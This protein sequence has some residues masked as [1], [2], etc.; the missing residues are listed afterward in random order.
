MMVFPERI[1][2]IASWNKADKNPIAGYQIAF[3]EDEARKMLC[4]YPSPSLSFESKEYVDSIVLR[5]ED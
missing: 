4:S 2:L 5:I 3:T 1:W